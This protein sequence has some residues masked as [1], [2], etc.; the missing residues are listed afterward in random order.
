MR[1]RGS[2]LIEK[3][4]IKAIVPYFFLSLLLLTMILYLQQSSRFA[5]LLLLTYAPRA[6]VTDVAI[7]LLPTVLAFTLPMAMLAG[8]IIGFSR[9]R[10]DSELVA[11][12]AAGVSSL[13]ILWPP[14]LM[15]LLLSVVAFYINFE[16][17]PLA[18]RSL[19]RAGLEAALHK[20]DSPVEPRTFNTEIPGYALYV[21]DGDS[22]QGRWER[23]F[24][25]SQDKNGSRLL[26]TA[27]SGRIDAA[28][29]QSELVLT[30]AVRTTL[31]SEANLVGGQYITERLTDLRFVLETGR[32]RLLARMQENETEP[33]EL[34]LFEL[35]NYV[36]THSIIE[37]RE[38][39]TLLHRKF[40]LTLAPLVFALLGG[41]LSLHLKRVGKGW[42]SLLSLVTLIAYYM[43]SLFGDALARK[44]TLPPVVGAWLSTVAAAAVSILLLLASRWSLPNFLRKR[45]GRHTSSKERQE[46][47]GESG[48]H[49]R[50]LGFPSILDRSLLRS[51]ALN[52]SF[53]YFALVAIFLI[54]TSFELLRFVVPGRAGMGI[55]ARYL[56][57]LVPFATV[58]LMPASLLI[59]VLLTYALMA[60]RGEAIAWW[61]SGQ[62]V[63]RLII[64]GV[65]FALVIG[66]LAWTIQ[67]R[68][69]PQA[70]V[71]QD[72]LRARIRSGITKAASNTGR[73]WLAS[74]SLSPNLIY[75]YEYD[76]GQGSLKDPVIYEFD[77]GGIHLER[78]VS[79]AIGTW[80]EETLEIADASV[81]E[82][83]GSNVERSKQDLARISGPVTPEMFKGGLSK[84][85]Q[86]SSEKLSAYI[87]AMKPSGRNLTPLVI[88]LQRKY[89]EP[90][91]SWIMALFGI[92]LA[93]SF[94]RR[95]AIIALCSAIGISLAYWGAVGGFQMLGEYGVL[96]PTLAAWFPLL[97]FAMLGVYFLT[98][99]RT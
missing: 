20:L 69:M 96:S 33:D 21:G 97:I 86:L 63:Y 2:R 12:R 15:G 7:S 77:S 61:S 79:G 35:I 46:T 28:A 34:G 51:L 23:V 48:V 40:S 60:R 27:A 32:T 50:M 56:L 80:K 93:L 75:S 38:A 89:A 47:S 49:Q 76:E 90:H 55:L 36:R 14:L 58:Q 67:E 1:Q 84:P 53:A 25:Y 17:A 66:L 92:P 43:L 3:Y 11:I 88:A 91:A 83:R 54:V 26:I 94:G 45:Q 64:P 4:I 8:T 9:M 13:N 57:Y 99:A 41:T 37:G 82:L 78:V 87:D 72:F 16:G 44:G 74:G 5:E 30:D 39:A 71:E 6:L 73:Q 68:I 95:G 98:R 24:I 65:A 59:A 18:N 29:A 22:A 52:F 62:S 42:G 85:A 10:S 19:E 70:N 31:P 81:V